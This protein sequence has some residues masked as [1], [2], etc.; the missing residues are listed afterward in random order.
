MELSDIEKLAKLSRLT[1]TEEEKSGFLNDLK[2]ILE[3]V[4][5]IKE[6]AEKSN[7]K[8][9]G[10]LRNVMREDNIYE[11]PLGDR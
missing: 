8:V 1:L 10:E 6:V 2:N 4:G 9:V 11:S 7:E 3:Y 5:E